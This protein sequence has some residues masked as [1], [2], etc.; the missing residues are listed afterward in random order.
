MTLLFSHQSFSTR[1]KM[2]GIV[3][4][5]YSPPIL[6]DETDSELGRVNCF[7]DGGSDQWT[8]ELSAQQNGCFETINI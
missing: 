8:F 2:A 7:Q 6:D 4:M 3:N 1:A 5:V